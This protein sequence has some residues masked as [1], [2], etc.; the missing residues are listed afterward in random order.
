MQMLTSCPAQRGWLLLHPHIKAT[1]QVHPPVRHEFFLPLWLAS[2][3]T[4]DFLRQ[5]LALWQ[6]TPDPELDCKRGT[7]T[8]LALRFLFRG[9][10]EDECLCRTSSSSPHTAPLYA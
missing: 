7:R 3:S 5:A 1:L 6:D 8:A 9:V 10:P 2:T 4:S